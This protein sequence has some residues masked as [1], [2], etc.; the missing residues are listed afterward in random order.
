MKDLEGLAQR[1][2]MGVSPDGLQLHYPADNRR[3]ER[4]HRSVR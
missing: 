2:A 3:I 4:Y 1:L